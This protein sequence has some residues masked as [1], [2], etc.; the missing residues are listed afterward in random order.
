MDITQATTTSAKPSFTPLPL[1]VIQRKCDCGGSAGISG[2]CEECQEKQLSINRYSTDRRPPSD[3]LP[4][5]FDLARSTPLP[6]SGAGVRAE[7]G[8]NFGRLRVGIVSQPGDRSE[9]EADRAAA[10][11][12]RALSAPVFEEKQEAPTL[13]QTPPLIQ[14]QLADESRSE[15][16][17]AP[18]TTTEP[19]TA[20]AEET[21]APG[22]IVEDDAAEIGPGQM[23]KSDF[24]DRLRA[25]VCAA[26]DAELAAAGRSTEGCP[27]IERAFE[28]YRNFSGDQLE[29]VLRR[30]A[31]EAA[32][33]TSAQDYIPIVSE[34]VRRAV[35]LWATTGR[36]TGAPEGM[37]AASPEAGPGNGAESAAS[38][39]GGIQFKSRDGGAVEAESPAEIQSQLG[40]GRPLDGG[41]KSRMESAFG[42]DFSRVRVHT[43]AKAAKL[44]SSLNARAFTIGSDIAFGSG[45]Y[46]PGA[47]IG[48]TLIAHELAHVVQ[49]GESDSSVSPMRVGD[50]GYNALEEDADLSAIGAVAS[51]W[52]GAKGAFR[53]IARNAM[54]RL[55]SGLS[56]RRCPCN[57]PEET[58][59]YR[60]YSQSG[61]PQASGWCIYCACTEAKGGA[62]DRQTGP[63]VNGRCPPGRE[64]RW[65]CTT[66]LSDNPLPTEPCAQSHPRANCL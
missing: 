28:R 47:L 37:M 50:T 32:G 62:N 11:V 4:S 63:G 20:A 64:M 16:E 57:T 58:I 59:R 55:R 27:Y 22:L 21:P 18:E 49:Q 29:R 43:D 7:A 45:E 53:D 2:E 19:E 25:A 51:L 5:P 6:D 15:A 36:I 52:S 24:L 60:H 17:A 39:P 38:A 23:R 44:S 9:L 56:L 40:S 66:V 42:Y 65:R 26:A 8:H 46:Q 41:V 1:G 48:D 13:S 54:P 31:P 10:T 30:Y 35:A 61:F 33:A 12:M 14:R 34:K 3:L